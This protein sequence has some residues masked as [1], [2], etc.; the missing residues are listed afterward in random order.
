MFLGIAWAFAAEGYTRLSNNPAERPRLE[1][2]KAAISS[3]KK[4]EAR[5]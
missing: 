3:G 2:L 5:A 1:A 4:R